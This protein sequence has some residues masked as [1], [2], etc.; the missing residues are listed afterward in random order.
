MLGINKTIM[1]TLVMWLRAV[2]QQPNCLGLQ[3][4]FIMLL[5]L[6]STTLWLVSLLVQMR[7]VF[8]FRFVVIVNK[9][10]HSR[11]Y[12]SAKNNK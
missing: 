4:N 12:A 9:L 7:A 11:M 8:P 6:N 3:S 10:I 1:D 2:T 5:A